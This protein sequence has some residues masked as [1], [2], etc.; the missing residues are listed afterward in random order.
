MQK[1]HLP[2]QKKSKFRGFVFGA[3]IW[4]RNATFFGHFYRKS[5]IFGFRIRYRIWDRKT[6]SRIEAAA[7]WQWWHAV[8]S[9]I[10]ASKPILKINMDETSVA[11]FHGSIKGNVIKKRKSEGEPVQFADRKKRRT[12]F[13]HAAFICDN[14]RVQRKLP[15]LILGNTNIL[16]IAKY[17]AI[18]ARRPWNVY[19]KAAKSAWMNAEVMKTLVDTLAVHI[20]DELEQYQVVL[21]LDAAKCHID[22]GVAQKCNQHGIILIILPARMTWLIQPCDTHLFA[23]YKRHMRKLWLDAVANRQ[24]SD[25][26]LIDLFTIIF[27]TIEDVIESRSWAH[28]FKED[29]YH[30]NFGQMSKYIMR[31]LEYTERPPIITDVPTYETVA[32]CYPSNVTV[33]YNVVLKPLRATPPALEA[34]VP[35]PPPLA[36]PPAPPLSQEELA[37]LP[38]VARL[39]GP[40][41]REQSEASGAASSSCPAPRAPPPQP[42]IPPEMTSRARKA[43]AQSLH[44]KAEPDTGD[45][46]SQTLPWTL[47]SKG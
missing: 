7:G 2:N 24:D 21:F 33:P 1:I 11:A 26:D 12:A 42:Q 20:R 16:T 35:A 32:L 19:V 15:Q 4:D 28:A 14:E 8:R 13:T 39:P 34:P 43:K 44:V 37:S 36:L 45:G 6:V 22:K 31:Q 38:K 46:G 30:D 17:N 18:V 47:R 3:G 5:L 41:R 40:R 23:A 27:R 9:K 29:G 10:N 25:L